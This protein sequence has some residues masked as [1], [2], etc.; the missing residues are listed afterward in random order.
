M[1]CFLD[2]ALTLLPATRHAIAKEGR[3][4]T[5]YGKQFDVIISVNIQSAVSYYNTRN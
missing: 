2:V 4:L 5:N 3:E 1:T